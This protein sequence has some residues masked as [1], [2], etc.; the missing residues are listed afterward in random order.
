VARNK[1]WQKGYFSSIAG[2]LEF[3]ETAEEAVLR[4]VKEEL[5][6][7]GEVRRFL[8]YYSIFEKNLRI[9]AFEVNGAGQLQLNEELSESKLMSKDEL[10]KYDFSYCDVTQQIIKVWSKPDD[11]D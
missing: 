11:F 5:N 3:G 7:T 10:S 4:E 8:G 2:Y 1:Q 6:L 9:L